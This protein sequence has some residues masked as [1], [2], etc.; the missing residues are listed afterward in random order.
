[1]DLESVFNPIRIKGGF[2]FGTLD[3]GA[4]CL[5]V[6]R[7]EGSARLSTRERLAQPAAARIITIKMILLK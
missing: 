7:I 5:P 1:M 3:G 6:G 2:R 4:I